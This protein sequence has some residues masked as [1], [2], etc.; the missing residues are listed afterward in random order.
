MARA[1]Q[2]HYLLEEWCRN[3]R[4]VTVEVFW[5]VISR[6][7]YDACFSSLAKDKLLLH[8]PRTQF[9]LNEIILFYYLENSQSE[10]GQE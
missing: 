2:I 4:K 7:F 8:V 3:V 9:I 1:H 10:F 5:K 6:L